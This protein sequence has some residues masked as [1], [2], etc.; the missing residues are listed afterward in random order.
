MPDNFGQGGKMN[1]RGLYG[2]NEGDV[3]L[4]ATTSKTASATRRVMAG[5]G[6]MP[7]PRGPEKAGKLE[8]WLY[9]LTENTL[10][11]CRT[12]QIAREGTNYG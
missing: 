2:T 4:W 5:A 1:R 10:T 3:W 11:R 12:H 6:V 7:A 9:S 8:E